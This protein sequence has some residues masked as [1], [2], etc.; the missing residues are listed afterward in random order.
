MAGGANAEKFNLVGSDPEACGVRHFGG[1]LVKQADIGI[2]DAVAL[3]ADQMRVGIRLVAVVAV[4][5][6]GKA[7]FQNFANLFQQ[8]DGFVDRGEAGGREI[9]FDLVINLFNA[10]MLVG[11]EK[12]LQDGYPL[13]RDAEFPLP[14][15]I[16]EVIQAFLRV[17]H[18]FTIIDKNMLWK[19]IINRQSQR[20]Q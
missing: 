2:D 6:I 8:I 18:G 4:A 17:S 19:M 5:A 7:D 11:I 13:G 10:R 12:R 16:E 20:H 15:F 3:G 1:K 9:D 14:K